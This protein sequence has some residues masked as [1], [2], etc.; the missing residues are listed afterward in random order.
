MLVRDLLDLS[1]EVRRYL[2]ARIPDIC[3]RGG[4]TLEAV[5]SKKKISIDEIVTGI[6]ARR[7]QEKP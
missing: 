7:S 6:E 3:C 4:D 2:L 1:P 5:A